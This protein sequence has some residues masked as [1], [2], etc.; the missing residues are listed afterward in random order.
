S[1]FKA[2]AHFLA[3]TLGRGQS[4]EIFE[5]LWGEF[6]RGNRT[7]TFN[8]TLSTLGLET[9]DQAI[10]SLVRVYRNHKPNLRLGL[11]TRGLLKSLKPIFKMGLLT[12]GYLPSQK[13]KVRALK[14]EK[15]FEAILYTE[16][17][18]REFWKPSPRGFERL[19]DIM[20]CP[21]EEMAYV[22]DNPTKDFLA[23]NQLGWTT[24]QVLRPARI[25]VHVASPNPLA[26]AHHLLDDLTALPTLLEDLAGQIR[27]QRTPSHTS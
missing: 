14:L 16:Q 18:G 12:D 5:T 10:R 17:L 20:K 25:H 15:W 1:G 23:P 9:D 26:A 4:T 11:D 19:M 13:L 6:E 2:V 21:A 3:D 24:I 27:D 8:A 22:G 7:Q